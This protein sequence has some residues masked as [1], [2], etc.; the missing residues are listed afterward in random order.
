M[1]RLGLLCLVFAVTAAPVW[2]RHG[3][4]GCG[5]TATTPAEVLFLHRQAERARAARPRPLAAATASTNR[6]IGNLAIIENRDGVVETLNQFDLDHAT[7]T[8][9][10]VSGGTPGY[11]YAYSGPGYDGSA[12]TQGSLVAALG[13]DDARQFTLPFAFPFYGAAYRQVYLNSDGNLTFTA[14][15]FASTSRSLGRMTGGPPRIA[16]LFDDLDP[17]QPSGSVRFYA[18]A[19]HVVFS[20]VN[21]PEWAQYGLGAPQT[22][23]VRL[24]ADGSI[25]FSYSGVSPTSAVVGIAPG[26]DQPGTSVVSFLNDASAEYP[27]A[28]AETFGS[29]PEID[30]VTV[31]QKFYETHEDAYDYL[32]IYN[33]MEIAAMTGA[34]AYETT[35]RSSGIGY[36]VAPADYGP[37]YGSAARLRSV[38][39]MGMLDNYPLDVTAVVPLR[40][41]AQDTP[42][43]VLGHESGHLFL[44]YASI[45]DPND[46]T[47]KPMLGYG[48]VH[49]SF[50]FNSEASLDEGEQINDLGG[51]SF[52]TGTVTQG[53][54]PLDRYLMGFAPS[55]DV[56]DTFVVLKPSA[57]PLGHPQSGYFFTGTKFPISVNDVI[58]A[59]GRRT[60]DY[61]VAQHRF[62]FGFVLVVPEGAQDSAIAPNVQQVETYRQQ[63]VAAYTKFSNNLGA[64][65]TTLNRSVRLSLFPAAGVVAGGSAS[66]TISLQT[67]PTA[68]L[69][70]KLAG[71]AGFAQAPAQVTIAAGATSTSFT[72]SGI[73]AGVEELLATPA[74][75][76]Y[77]VAYARVQVAAPSQVTLGAVSGDNQVS[78]SAGP[79][80]APV[81]VRVSDANGLPYPGAR[82]QAVAA[83][84]SVTPAIAT[85]DAS[86][87]ASFIWAPGAGSANQLTLSLEAAPAVTLTLKAGSAVP[88]ILSVE[89]AASYV[90]GVAPGS[91]ATLFG[92]NLGGASVLL[93]GAG[94]QSSYA[95]DT[96]INFY[97]PAET[98]VGPG[99]VTVNAPSGLQVSS[100]INLVAVQPGIFSG[101]V[102]HAGTLVSAFNAP[103]TAGDYIEIYCTGLGPT[104]ISNGLSL[105]T[106]TPTVY[107]GNTAV[108]P[109]YSGLAPGFVGL[110]QVNVQIPAGLVPGPLGVVLTSG[111]AYSNVARIAVR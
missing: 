62:R 58:Q 80:P 54:A 14:A 37:Q 89:N 67:P 29:T 7:L 15:E 10:P 77:E 53:F 26:S 71:L 20:W 101:A 108:T 66:A 102:V 5:T 85:A 40:A 99:V 23:Q 52:I 24:Y 30:I 83:G 97:L 46:P 84:G 48:G 107:L 63:F 3:T 8:F 109:A 51:G 93:N 105:T 94:V 36:S 95:S 68:D 69:A 106:V 16:P 81:V 18:D 88:V 98:P 103:V 2:A 28:V 38:M 82:I 35:V 44:A 25:Q 96:Q 32:V 9:T 11:R 111:N 50:V 41:A 73:K 70:V 60:P 65:D 92:V 91:L 100:K 39:N 59:V 43:T 31:A 74:D 6:D 49:W 17:S 79:L 45:P 76:S 13:D 64:A 57:S 33:N 42:L 86:G 47:A 104:R 87:Q 4:A 78:T 22:F 72:V 19:S 110:Y 1:R 75:A 55:S 21:V 27:A 90:A 61:T 56:P 12:A 34:V